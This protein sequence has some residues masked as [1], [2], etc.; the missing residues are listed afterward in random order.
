MLQP[1]TD[2][3]TPDHEPEAP[4]RSYLMAETTV[5]SW[6]NTRDHKRVGLMFLVA[7]LF[8]LF[9]GGVFAMVLRIELLTPDR[10]II[11]PVAYNRLFTLH[12]IVM[13]FLFLVLEI[14][15]LITHCSIANLPENA[16]VLAVH[17]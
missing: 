16:F 17:Q 7:L 3:P 13:I 1:A 6:L 2:S 10:T 9:L 15:Q 14:V 11:S 8:A 5:A 12:G 4:R